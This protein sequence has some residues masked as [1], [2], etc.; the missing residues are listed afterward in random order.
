[1]TLG[2][3]M[4]RVGEYPALHAVVT[5]GEP[6]IAPQTAELTHLL[7]QA[8]L[9]ITIET[10]G[11]AWADVACDL[12][13]VSPKLSNSTPQGPFAAQHDRLRIQPAILSRLLAA[14]AHQVK[15]VIAQPSDNEEIRALVQQLGVSRQHVILMPEG[16][17]ASVLHERGKWVSELCKAEGYRYSPRLHVE[18][19]GNR[20]GV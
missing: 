20:R 6:M 1:M 15:F 19:Y 9:H 8:G 12:L 4:N 5:G 18:L 7:R 2:A 16:I 10:A 17:D 3:I 14:Y 13:S 11:T